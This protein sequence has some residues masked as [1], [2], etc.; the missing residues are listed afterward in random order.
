MCE[1]GK[2][3]KCMWNQFNHEAW[4]APCAEGAQA[5]QQSSRLLGIPETIAALRSPTASVPEFWEKVLLY[6]LAQQAGHAGR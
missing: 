4:N 2:H 3:G 1:R 6:V 5:H